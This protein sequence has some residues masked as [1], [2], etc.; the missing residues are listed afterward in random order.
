MD[1]HCRLYLVEVNTGTLL[2]G[3]L[4]FRNGT[5]GTWLWILWIF[6]SVHHHCYDRS[7]VVARRDCAG[8]ERDLA[9]RRAIQT[10]GCPS[11]VSTSLKV[12]E[13]LPN[14]YYDE[15]ENYWPSVSIRVFHIHRNIPHGRLGIDSGN[16]GGSHGS[17]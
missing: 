16:N 11:M 4:L 8:K 10:K 9:T 1:L 6:W 2:S 17:W 5:R 3:L 15:Q 12:D 14:P 7:V 13:I